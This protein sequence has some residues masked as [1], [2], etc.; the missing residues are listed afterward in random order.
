MKNLGSYLAGLFEG[1]GYIWIPDSNLKK[2]ANPRFCITSHQKN[3]GFLEF[4]KFNLGGFGF[5]RN[6]T[7][8]HALVLTIS[9]KRGLYK[10]AN[11]L[12]LN[13]RTPKIEQVARLIDWLNDNYLNEFPLSSPCLSSEN[14]LSDRWLA[15]FIEAD[16]NFN[17]RITEGL[18]KNRVGVSFCVNQR[19]LDKWGNSY[20][21]F[22]QLIAKALLTKLHVIKKKQGSYFHIH[23]SSL[24][25]LN[26]LDNYLNTFTLISSKREDYVAWAEVLK[27]MN[28][29]KH[30]LNLTYIKHLKSQ[31]NS[32]RSSINWEF[33]KT[34]DAV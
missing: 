17:I 31:M 25:A 7:S 30:Y 15:G 24:T 22:M 6:K 11:Y 29:K 10:I 16:G 14:L 2:K 8:K 3:K 27:L 21:N 28:L 32:R 18:K 26:L 20:E 12:L 1:D 5:I 34:G 9:N 23:I 19:M 13:C 33:L 4:L